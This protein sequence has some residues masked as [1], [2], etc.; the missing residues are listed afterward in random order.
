MKE[1]D[2]DDEIFNSTIYFYDEKIDILLNSDYN[3]FINNICKIIQIPPEQFNSLKIS[4]LDEDGDSI[5][6]TSEEDYKI[7]FQQIK[8]KTVN[9]INLE[10]DENSN[11]NPIASFGS[12]LDYKEQI[13]QANKKI[14]DDKNNNSNNIIN[15]NNI[16]DNE[17]NNDNIR[18][19]FDNSGININNII[20]NEEFDNEDV[21]ID[22]IVFDYKCSSCSTY[23]IICTIH[24]CSLCPL[25]LCG[26]C[27]K[28]Y[29][30]HMHPLQK[31]E[32][33]RELIKIKEK[34]N[35]EIEK[36]NQRKNIKNN[37]NS[38]SQNNQLNNNNLAYS[39]DTNFIDG[40]DQL[41]F[42]LLNLLKTLNPFKLLK[43]KKLKYILKKNKKI[44]NNMAIV[45][46]AKQK[47]NLEGID[48]LKLLE[49]LNQ[50]NGDID[51]ALFL[52]NK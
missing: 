41:N 36:M 24:Y 16:N 40:N 10:I 50:T 30:N 44:L 48:D 25:Y 27:I 3:T 11:I 20:N 1:K 23:P 22:D 19:N 39:N 8:D 51:Q 42:N 35:N 12:A 29:M 52:L 7:F 15:I 34:E 13:E 32:S 45:H 46:K 47:Y 33:R 28:N 5:I 18:Y 4:Y 26:D 14:E 6:L 38:I 43:D 49:A 21:P 2:D 31:Y 9:G 37:E 17:N